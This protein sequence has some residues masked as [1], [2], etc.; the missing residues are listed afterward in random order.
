MVW[1]V[2]LVLVPAWRATPAPTGGS[3]RSILSATVDLVAARVCHRRPD[4]TLQ[5][6]GEHLPVCGR[7]TALYFGGTAGLLLALVAPI[8]RQG[9]AHRPAATTRSSA[10]WWP[11]GLDPRAAWLALAATP[12]ALTWGLESVAVWDPGTLVRALAALPL[13]A[14]AG[15]FIARALLADTRRR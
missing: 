10:A 5:L 7:C 9:R 15:W 6:R 2:L 1:A 13:G 11:A 8:R 4:R 3:V 12:T 14:T